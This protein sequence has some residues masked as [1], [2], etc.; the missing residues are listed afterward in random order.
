MD[1][2][3]GMASGCRVKWFAVMCKPR[4]EGLAER[5]LRAQGYKTFFPHLTY[6]TKPRVAR[7]R[8]IQ[9]AYMPRYIFA[10]FNGNPTHSVYQMNNT[11]GVSTVV[12]YG[13]MALNIPGRIMDELIGR[14]DE[15]GEIF[16]KKQPRPFPAKPGDKLK[17]AEN[18]PFWGLVCE[19]RRVDIDDRLVVCLDEMLGAT[20]REISIKR[21][22]VSSFLKDGMEV[23]LDQPTTHEDH[24]SSGVR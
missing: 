1:S 22:D 19:L 24:H 18:S 11:I 12:Y 7:P 3:P 10:S 13:N 17:F 15:S 23:R 5:N 9:K 16:V 4:K 8:Q 20:G 6:W 14:A 2:L 21:S